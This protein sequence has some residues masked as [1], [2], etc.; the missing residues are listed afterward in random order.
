MTRIQI[1]DSG[2]AVLIRGC[3]DDFSEF[4]KAT[5][6]WDLDFRQ[7]DRGASPVE[8]IQVMTRYAHAIHFRFERRYHQQG[9]PPEGT[10]NFGFPEVACEPMGWCGDEVEKSSLICFAPGSD[11]TSISRA[12]FAGTTLSFDVGHL[13]RVADSLGLADALEGTDKLQLLTGRDPR[14]VGRLRQAIADLFVL[15]DD[16][17]TGM[18]ASGIATLLED[19]ISTRLVEALASAHNASHTARPSL[20][21]RTKARRRAVAFIDAHAKEAPSIRQVCVDAGVSWRTMNYAFK[22]YFGVTPKEYL[23]TVRL[24]GVRR[25][26]QAYDGEAVIADIANKWG[27]WHM[28]QFAAD[29]RLKFGELPSVTRP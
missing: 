25:E 6:N 18:S 12:G 21:A 22:E 9:S 23:Q 24:H 15:A 1:Q 14:V 8:A 16:L 13:T 3:F 20:R 28:G 27:F 17:K 11:Y 5:E 26:L 7:L 10:L 2:P 29:Y 19:E 4:D